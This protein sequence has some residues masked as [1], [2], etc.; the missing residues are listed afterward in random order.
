MKNTL[1]LGMSYEFKVLKALLL[2]DNTEFLVLED[3]FSNKH[4]LPL[5]Y[6]SHYCI[7]KQSVIRCY[8]DKINCKGQI[9]LD[10]EHPKYK[11]GESYDFKFVRHSIL[12]SK[13][14][15]QQKVIIV[16][17][18][19]NEECTLFAENWQMTENYQPETLRCKVVRIKKGRLFLENCTEN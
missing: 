3:Q 8:V 5:Q 18:A 4:L 12:L 10:P 13:K 11:I 14:Q 9:F 7:E 6:Y 19:E 1:E 15:K 2:P 16:Q 17:N